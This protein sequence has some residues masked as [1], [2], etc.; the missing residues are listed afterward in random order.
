MNDPDDL[1]DEV[2]LNVL[3]AEGVDV[4][5]AHEASRISSEPESVAGQADLPKV[6]PHLVWYGVVLVV[7]LLV[8]WMLT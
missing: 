3:L 1:I 2:A 7:A 6:S 8:I 4:P 5:T